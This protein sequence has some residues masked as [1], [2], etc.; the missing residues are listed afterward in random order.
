MAIKSA[1]TNPFGQPLWSAAPFSLLPHFLWNLNCGISISHFP[2]TLWSA[3]SVADLLEVRKKEKKEKFLHMFATATAEATLWLVV[4]LLLL[5][6]L[7]VADATW[8]WWLIRPSGRP[9]WMV[10]HSHPWGRTNE[11][12]FAGDYYVQPFGIQMM[13]KFDLYV[14][15]CEQPKA[16]T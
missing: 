16:G 1:W 3:A 8:I 2:A 4:L 9:T 11:R 12:N 10:I 15:L 5:L 6:L 13:C 14:L 7:V